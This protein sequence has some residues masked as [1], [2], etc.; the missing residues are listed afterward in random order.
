M[1]ILIINGSPKGKYSVTLQTCNYLEILHPEHSFQVLHAG[2]TIKAL[3]KDF[4]P[5]LAA[6]EKADLLLF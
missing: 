6:V 4:S 1:H 3:E 5:A 2:Q